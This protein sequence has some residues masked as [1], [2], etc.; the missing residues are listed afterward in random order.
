[1]LKKR[2]SMEMKGHSM[3]INLAAKNLNTARYR[4]QV[5]RDRK[6]YTRKGKA[7][8]DNE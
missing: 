1:M 5:V 4:K 7:Q 8:K 6:I 2:I 3:Q